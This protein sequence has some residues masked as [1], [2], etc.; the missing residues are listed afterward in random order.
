[1]RIRHLA[2]LLFLSLWVCA[3]GEIRG[4]KPDLPESVAPDWKLA[5]LDRSAAPP[6]LPYPSSR[7]SVDQVQE[8]PAAGAPDCWQAHYAGSGDAQVWICRYRAEDGAFDA[9]QRVQADA[10]TV[11]F[12]EGAYLVLVKG[13][14]APN[15]DLI[16]LMRAIQSAIGK[17]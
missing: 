15:A 8:A 17:K 4:T 3:C 16:A 9:W 6:Y 10:A 14:H 5:S 1:M 13:N 7:N 12:Q 2:A 11:K